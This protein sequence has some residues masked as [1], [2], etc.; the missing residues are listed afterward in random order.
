MLVVMK[1]SSGVPAA[2]T[3]SCGLL[4]VLVPGTHLIKR[5]WAP[6]LHLH[7]YPSGRTATFYPSAQPPVIQ[8]L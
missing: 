1:L 8:A 4:F 2:L 5:P 7:L 3:T 6:C